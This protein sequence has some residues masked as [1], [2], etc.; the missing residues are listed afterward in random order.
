MLNCK[1]L[2]RLVS[3]SLTRQLTVREKLNLW[4]HI[5]CVAHAGTSEYYFDKSTPP[6]VSRSRPPTHFIVSHVFRRDRSGAYRR[7][8]TWRYEKKI[9]WFG[10]IGNDWSPYCLGGVVIDSSAL[11]KTSPEHDRGGRRLHR[12][13]ARQTV[14]R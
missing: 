1:D 11:T 14:T 9:D 13:S 12:N 8:S 6:Y 2:S 10:I 7:R 4:M 5:L 3:D